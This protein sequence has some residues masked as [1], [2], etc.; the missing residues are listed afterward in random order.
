MNSGGKHSD[1]SCI[2][3]REARNTFLHWATMQARSALGRPLWMW[4]KSHLCIRVLPRTFSLH[5]STDHLMLGASSTQEKCGTI[6]F[7]SPQ[8]L[9]FFSLFSLGWVP[10]IIIK[11]ENYAWIDIIY[12]QDFRHLE[13]VS[14]LRC[15][16]SD[17][18]LLV[19]GSF[20]CR[21]WQIRNL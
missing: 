7:H 11:H 8:Y 15:Y 21:G 5:R 3:N 18:T 13:D 19:I 20:D 17:P 10:F 6:G 9:L 16:R 1:Y 12:K 2:Q 14:L 4:W